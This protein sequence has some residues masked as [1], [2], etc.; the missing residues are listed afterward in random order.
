[1]ETEPSNRL[2]DD[3]VF[4]RLLKITFLSCFLF[5]F[6]YFTCADYAW[7]YP[8]TAFSKYIFDRF[9]S[10]EDV[11][12]LLELAFGFMCLS[13]ITAVPGLLC[14]HHVAIK[15]RSSTRKEITYTLVPAIILGG[16]YSFIIFIITGDTTST[17]KHDVLW[18]PF[19]L[20]IVIGVFFY[21]FLIKVK[22]KPIGT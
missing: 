21:L 16:L 15:Y 17:F 3:Q 12:P 5:F 20:W 2:D 11:L 8:D 22:R 10:F 4:Y 18:F 1:M 13:S 7:L 19:S 14:M 9:S 6:V